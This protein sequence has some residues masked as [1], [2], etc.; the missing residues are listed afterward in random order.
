M[1]YILRVICVLFGD[2]GQVG[3]VMTVNSKKRLFNMIT[4]FLV[5]SPFETGKNV[6]ILL[7]Y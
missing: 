7:L 6:S 2:Y 4:Y 3:R 5:P 1:K